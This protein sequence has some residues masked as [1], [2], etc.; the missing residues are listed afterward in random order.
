MISE[1]SFCIHCPAMNDYLFPEMSVLLKDFPGPKSLE[2]SGIL[3][4]IKNGFD[5]F[6]NLQLL[7]LIPRSG[8]L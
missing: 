5:F 6:R 3:N 7:K 4:A 2:I 8:L 1:I